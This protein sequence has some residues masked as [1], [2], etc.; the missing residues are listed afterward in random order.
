MVSRS[1]CSVRTS[2]T[3]VA[4]SAAPSFMFELI[5]VIRGP[6]PGSVPPNAR[7]TTS[8]ANVRQ[9]TPATPVAHQLRAAT[10]TPSGTSDPSATYGVNAIS[11]STQYVRSIPN[12]RTPANTVKMPTSVQVRTSRTHLDADRRALAGASGSVMTVSAAIAGTLTI[13]A[14]LHGPNRLTRTFQPC[15]HRSRADN[16]PRDSRPSG[17]V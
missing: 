3:T 5:T 11:M 8:S 12:S 7:G 15:V 4:G 17:T 1:M 6:R 16:G 14:V 13:P 2:P 10:A 9:T